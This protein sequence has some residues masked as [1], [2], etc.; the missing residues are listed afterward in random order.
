MSRSLLVVAGEESG[1]LHA[2][3][4]VRALRD[5]AADVSCWGIGGDRLRAEG[6]ELRRHASEM[7]AIGLSE[8]IRR[9]SFF[10]RVFLD[11]VDEACRRRPAA[12][13]LVDYPGFNVRL[14]ARLRRAGIPV[15]YYIS[16]QVWA[17]NRSRIRVMAEAVDRLLVI[18]PFEETVFAGTGLPV[19]F[20]GHPLAETA[21]EL[22]ASDP[23]PLPWSG[24]RKAALLPGSRLQEIRRIFP[25]FR[26][27]AAILAERDPGLSFLVASPGER[28]TGALEAIQDLDRSGRPRLEI[29]TGRTREVL[30][31]A[32]AAMV[33]SGT[34]TI[35]TALL[36]CPMIVAYKTSL[37]TYWIARM[38]VKVDYLG[39]VNLLAGRELCPEFIQGAADPAAVARAFEPLPRDTPERAAQLAGLRGIRS[40]LSAGRGP[41]RVAEVLAEEMDRDRSDSNG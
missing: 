12:A 32:D 4:V 31:Q 28:I 20:V 30:R 1:D 8:V 3:P 35:E 27:A 34:A 33:A 38:V 41:A 6:M 25:V 24:P 11:L 36:G 17:W 15:V 40:A 13:L 39:M 22:L 9:F 10:R 2:A 21:K 7:E 37:L 26:E 19:E 29:V 16:P 18:F 23:A 5:V 14:A